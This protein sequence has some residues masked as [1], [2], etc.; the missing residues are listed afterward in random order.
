[1]L[2][3]A[4]RLFQLRVAH[5]MRACFQPDLYTNMTERGDRL[6]EETLE[7]LQSGGYDCDRVAT[8]VKYVY[9]RP[10]GQPAQEVGGVMVTLA[11][12]CEIAG[13]D[14]NDAAITELERIERPEIMQKIRT[15]Q[16]AKAAIGFA[17]PAPVPDFIP[18]PADA[19]ED[20]PRHTLTGLGYRTIARQLAESWLAQGDTYGPS[21]GHLA[22]RACAE[23][24]LRSLDIWPRTERTAACTLP[25]PGWACSRGKGHDGPCAASEAPLGLYQRFLRRVCQLFGH[26]RD[27]PEQEQ[28]GRCGIYLPMTD[29]PDTKRLDAISSEY[30]VLAP[31]TMPTGQGDAD[32]GWQ[33][34]R[35]RADG[36]RHLVEIQFDDA[37]RAIDEA[38]AELDK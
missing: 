14:L 33:C 10:A 38:T 18:L 4:F 3:I 29:H 21:V 35:E 25:P 8:L 15:K 22:R 6:L 17:S 2:P 34:I 19:H 26:G 13:I 28:C 37:R 27:W 36:T 20:S 16:A 7:L 31:F 9:G 5:W 32:I 30:L 1:M 11:G 23:D 12:Y 24:L